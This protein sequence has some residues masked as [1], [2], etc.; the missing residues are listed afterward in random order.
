MSIERMRQEY[1]DGTLENPGYSDAEIREGLGM[2][3][4]AQQATPGRWMVGPMGA[5][6]NI[7]YSADNA[8]QTP[9]RVVTDISPENARLACAAVNATRE[10]GYSVDMLKA[11]CLNAD[12]AEMERAR[13]AEN[14]WHGLWAKADESN[15]R[16]KALLA[17]CREALK[18][19]HAYF[20]ACHEM[21][22]QDCNAH[23]TE[24]ARIRAYVANIAAKLEAQD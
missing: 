12:R 4:P 22:P 18:Q 23:G 13:K 7:H 11:G 20:E 5:L 6:A 16:D 9:I 24:G 3:E 19:V 8:A 15:I 2:P 17:E 1:A 21:R 10:A 14:K